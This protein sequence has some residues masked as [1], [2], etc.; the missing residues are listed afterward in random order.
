MRLGSVSYTFWIET[1]NPSIIKVGRLGLFSRAERVRSFL[2]KLCSANVSLSSSRT[3]IPDCPRIVISGMEL[4]SDPQTLFF[5]IRKEGSKISKAFNTLVLDTFNNCSWVTVTAE[6]VKLCLLRLD[7][8][9]VTTA[10]SICLIS[11]YMIILTGFWKLTLWIVIS[12]VFLPTKVKI[13]ITESV[14]GT[15]SRNC[16]LISELTPQ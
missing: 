14:A 5:W 15:S 7:V 11:S 3:P 10:S 9:P 2:S 6:P 16:P 12:L 1:S 13:S 8:I 4:G